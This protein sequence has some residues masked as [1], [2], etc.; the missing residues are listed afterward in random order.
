M[1]VRSSS[2]QEDTES[3]SLAGQFTSVLDVRGWA[4]FGTA[5]RPA[6]GARLLGPGPVA[7]TL[8]GQLLPLEADLWVTPMARGLAAAL[9]IGGSAPRRLLG[10]QRLRD[11]PARLPAERRLPAKPHLAAE[12]R[13]PAEPHLPGKP[14]LPRPPAS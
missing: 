3:S 5:A 12:R 1:V 14:R 2:P 6:R 11:R 10:R 7:E 9:D 8:P 4:D 13:L